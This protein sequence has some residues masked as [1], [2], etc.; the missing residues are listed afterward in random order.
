MA[1]LTGLPIDHLALVVLRIVKHSLIAMQGSTIFIPVLETD[2]VVSVSVAD[3][4]DD[5]DELLEVL[6]AE[7]APLALWI[8]VAK[9]YLAQGKYEQYEKVL[10]TGTSTE[11]EQFFCN[12][13]D[14]NYDP[15]VEHAYYHGVEY[16]RIQVLCSL[17]DYY[18]K[19]QKAEPNTHKRIANME[20]ASA[21]VA[22]AQKLGFS[23]Q[24]PRLM[25]AQL[26]LARVSTSA[27][28]FNPFHSLLVGN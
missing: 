20:K 5:A 15:S 3:L 17:A 11:T 9:A 13:K 6:T 24:I 18:S 26:T 14:S 1:N 23:E 25:D 12:P 10:E 4:P 16:D 2:D 21:L 27:W 8:E 22:R 28:Y 19:S 7:S